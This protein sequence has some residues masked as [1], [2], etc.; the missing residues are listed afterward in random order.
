VEHVLPQSP[1]AKSDWATLFSEEQAAY[2]VHRLGNLVLL[3]GKRNARAGNQGFQKKKESCLG[4]MA[5]YGTSLIPLSDSVMKEERWDP[6]VVQRRQ[7]E[8]VKMAIDCWRL[9][10]VTGAAAGDGNAPGTA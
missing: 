1:A 6:Q 7:Q 2:W 8:Q 3:H 9:H 5:M 10:S 4:P